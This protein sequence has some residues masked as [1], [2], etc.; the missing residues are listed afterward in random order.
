MKSSAPCPM[1][2]IE[3][4]SVDLVGPQFSDGKSGMDG[5]SA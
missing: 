5:L 1:S 3:E 4:K 2:S